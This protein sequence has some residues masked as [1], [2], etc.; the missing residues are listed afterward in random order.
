V[1]RAP[2]LPFVLILAV[3]AFA[4][5]ASPMDPNTLGPLDPKTL[6]PSDQSAP[7]RVISL[8][9]AVT[10]MLF[11][12]GAGDQVIGVSSYE[13]YPPEAKK[14][15]S[16]GALFDPNVES[17]LAARSDLVIVYG[18]QTEL[19]SRL[20]RASVPMF[21]YEHAGLAD[22]TSTIRS[23]G[24]RVGR[25]ARAQELAA[26]IERD[27]DAIRKSVAGKPR[28]KTALLFGREPGELRNIYAS[29]GVGFMHDMLEVA[30]GTDVFADVKRQNLQATT[31][32]LL[33]RAPEVI[34]EV[35]PSEGW[36]QARIDRERAVWRGL[37]SL[38]AVRSGRIHILA[39]DRLNIPG[40]RVA[41]GVRVLADAIHAPGK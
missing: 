38:P 11:A 28:P 33:T 27:L 5:S 26:S 6:G 40:P 18:S 8:V 31:E 7:S 19:I 36:T 23:I 14:R 2:V 34:V 3:V 24:E 39:D 4:I 17:I 25:R 35:H 9:P 32:I 30:G 20:Q 15:P 29:A 21:R 41:E 13:I 37:P 10:E 12:I 22:I 1:T 16:M